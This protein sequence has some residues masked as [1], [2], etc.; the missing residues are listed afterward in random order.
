MIPSNNQNIYG[1]GYSAIS[2]YGLAQSQPMAVST[3][4]YTATS[5]MSQQYGVSQQFTP[6]QQEMNNVQQGFIVVSGET[7][8]MDSKYPMNTPLFDDKEDIFYYKTYDQSAM[9]PIVKKARFVWE[10]NGI[11]DAPLI[12][13]KDMTYGDS[14]NNEINTIR[15]SI[16]DLAGQVATLEEMLLEQSTNPEKDNKQTNRNTSS[17]RKTNTNK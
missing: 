13:Q 5:P 1:T 16:Q 14:S 2:P 9:H 11:I 12:E 10:E 7:Q 17:T 15:K 8:A 4:V 3:P 6:P